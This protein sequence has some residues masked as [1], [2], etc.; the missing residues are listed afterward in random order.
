MGFVS[1][2]AVNSTR[3]ARARACGGLRE[4]G[5]GGA[6]GRSCVFPLPFSSPCAAVARL[7]RAPQPRRH[8]A[9]GQ[10]QPEAVRISR[11]SYEFSAKRNRL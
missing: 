3:T 7:V 6:R 1:D 2:G 10:N 9:D 5:E 8:L 11:I 4:R